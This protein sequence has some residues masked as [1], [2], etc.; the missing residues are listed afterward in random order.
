MHWLNEDQFDLNF[1][2]EFKEFPITPK[3]KQPKDALTKPE[4]AAAQPNTDRVAPAAE[5]VSAADFNAPE[6]IRA[7]AAQIEK[8]AAKYDEIPG[9]RIRVYD[10]EDRLIMNDFGKLKELFRYD[11]NGK[12]VEMISLRE[13]Q[14]PFSAEITDEGVWMTDEVGS[15]QLWK[16]TMAQTGDWEPTFG[17]LLKS[18]WWLLI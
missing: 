18:P 2:R 3:A 6:A 4:V 10:S 9:D 11:K 17:E 13:G 16:G 15:K 5:S 12:M 8:S 14:P 1:T 7:R